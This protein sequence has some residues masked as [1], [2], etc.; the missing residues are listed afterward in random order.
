MESSFDNLDNLLKHVRN[1]HESAEPVSE[2]FPTALAVVLISPFL[3]RQGHHL[4]S[5]GDNFR[6]VNS[7]RCMRCCTIS[8]EGSLFRSNGTDVCSAA[9]G[10]WHGLVRTACFLELN[11]S[12]FV[13]LSCE[14]SALVL[15]QVCSFN[16]SN[17]HLL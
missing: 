10:D 2:A 3:L 16:Q 9:C 6:E 4:L 7:T 11:P 5:H 17:Q 14:P 12:L 1:G 8:W 13:E 15:K